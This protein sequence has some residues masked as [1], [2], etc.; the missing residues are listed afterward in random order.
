M[1][2]RS[3]AIRADRR[4]ERRRVW[5]LLLAAAV[6]LAAIVVIRADPA[7]AADGSEPTRSAVSRVDLG[8][9]PLFAYYYIWYEPS[10]W[11][12]AK[13]DLPALGRYSSDDE[14]VMRQHVTWA[15]AAGIDAFIVSWK[16]TAVL[17]R[18]LE[19]L[20]RVARELDFKLAIIYQ[21]LDFHREP[22][23]TELIAED[24]DRFISHYASDPVFQI[25]DR[26]VVIWSGTWR[27]TPAEIEDVAAPRRDRLE[28][29]GSARSL[30][31]VVQISEILDGNAYY[32]SS[33]DP[34]TNLNY[35]KK[36]RSMARSVHDGG[37]RWIA[38][39]AP[40]FDATMLGGTTVVERDE[41]DTLALQ[42]DAAVRSLPEAVG[43]IS[44]NEFSENSHVEPSQTWGETYLS[45][46]AQWRNRP[47]IDLPEF[48]SSLPEGVN[49]T[50]VGPVLALTLLGGLVVGGLAATA[51][52][53]VSSQ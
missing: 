18:R 46:L 16:S 9:V 26:P 11:D 4:I 12:R 34:R 7:S 5:Q 29:L 36:L 43:L 28:I 6:F 1:A 30:E 48:D 52:R 47:A 27:F 51:R 8:S 15:K 10:S 41:G 38:P 39:A 35:E 33:V 3:A 37:G 19:S 25:W 23:G 17:D 24:L 20:M 45:L 32:W 44:W 50:A 22:R 14:A 49:T 2:D 40:G 42:L 31:E 53:R 13:S 21:G